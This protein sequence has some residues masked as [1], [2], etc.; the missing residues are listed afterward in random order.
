MFLLCDESCDTINIQGQFDTSKPFSGPGIKEIIK[1]AFFVDKQWYNV[2]LSNLG[3][4]RHTKGFPAI[5]P[6]VSPVMLALAATA[7][8]VV[9]LPFVSMLTVIVAS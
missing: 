9:T 6:E 5:E 4:F 8:C 3:I 7:V 2:G 1:A